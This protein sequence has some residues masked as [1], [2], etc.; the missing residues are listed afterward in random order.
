MWNTDED[1]SFTGNL[2]WGIRW[3]L[4]IAASFACMAAVP[5]FL[6]FVTGMNKV[7]G[8]VVPPFVHLLALYV[9]AGISAGLI[10]GTLRPLL[11]WWL[12]RRIV[13]MLATVPAS[14][15]FNYSMYPD[16]AW[17]ARNLE[18][19]L[20]FAAVYGFMMSFA[21]GDWPFGPNPRNAP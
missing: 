17:H 13:A 14:F 18:S 5:A 19:I 2:R 15:A 3:G 11:R 4:F 8:R 1:R 16:V 7:D 20:G 21:F 6:R 9:V 10:G 12:G